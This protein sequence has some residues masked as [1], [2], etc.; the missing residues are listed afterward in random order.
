MGMETINSVLS[1]EGTLSRG[2]YLYIP[3]LRM[4]SDGDM[5]RSSR[6]ENGLFISEIIYFFFS[7]ISRLYKICDF[8]L[9]IKF[10]FSKKTNDEDNDLNKIQ[11]D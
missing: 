6:N 10:Q 8:D 5:L 7:R 1:I 4:Q 11:E 3:Q 9:N 2:I